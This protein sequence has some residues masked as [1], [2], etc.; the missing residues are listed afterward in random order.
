MMDLA[1]LNAEIAAGMYKKPIDA[2]AKEIRSDPL[3]DESALPSLH[4]GNAAASCLRRP[5]SREYPRQQ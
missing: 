3:P 1:L 5:S 4:R 2:I